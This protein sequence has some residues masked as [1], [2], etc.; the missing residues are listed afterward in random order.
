MRLRAAHDEQAGQDVDEDAA[1]PGRHGVG[2]WGAEVDV[3]HH[4][5]DAD[6]EKRINKTMSLVFTLVI[7]ALLWF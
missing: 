5:G 1:D 4:H 6:A 2:L 3:Q 7:L